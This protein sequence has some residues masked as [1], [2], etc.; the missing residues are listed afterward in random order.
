M[1]VQQTLEIIRVR[2]KTGF[3]EQDTIICEHELQICINNTFKLQLSC[4][5]QNIEELVIG[6]LFSQGLIQ[7]YKDI[8]Q[9]QI[10]DDLSASVELRNFDGIPCKANICEAQQVATLQNASPQSTV[11]AA[12]VDE[13]LP[14]PVKALFSLEEILDQAASLQSRSALFQKTGGVHAC[15]LYSA[16][17]APYFMEDIGRHNAFDKTIGAALRD[18]VSF[19]HAMLLT[20][21]R[22]PNDILFKA[23]KAKLPIIV[24]R[25]APTAQ[26]VRIARDCNITLC[27]FARDKRINIYSA[28]ERIHGI[29]YISEKN[30]VIKEN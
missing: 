7:A 27:G 30:S 26:A 3:F 13:V 9:I 11:G 18:G 5:P 28:P 25:S 10:N 15:A 21:G 29:T 17:Q 12:L 6:H 22:V 19:S 2:N 16:A 24:S 1:Q 14:L 8:I 4:S 20:T 23:I